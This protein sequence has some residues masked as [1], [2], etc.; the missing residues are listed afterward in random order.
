MTQKR[1]NS[2]M[3]AHTGIFLDFIQHNDDFIVLM[4]SSALC[5][6]VC[7]FVEGGGIEVCVLWSMCSGVVYVILEYC[8]YHTVCPL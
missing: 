5:V 6:G 7:V 4:T 1:L 8:I 3:C 2:L